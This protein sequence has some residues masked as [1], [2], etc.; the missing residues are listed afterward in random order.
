MDLRELVE[1]IL[2]EAVGA[3]PAP[4][5]RDYHA[6]WLERGIGREEPDVMAALGGAL[7]DRLA[8]VFVAGY[9]ATIR[10]CFPDLPVEPGWCAFV[11]TEEPSRGLP[12]TALTGE[13]GK[14][15]LSGAKTWVAAADHVDRLLVSAR[16]N[17]VPFVVL[18]RDAPGVEIACD[19]P[20][21]YLSEMVQGTVTFDDI[22]VREEQL[23]G[24]ARTFPVFR[25]AESAYVR[26]ALNV[27]MHGHVCRL[28]GPTA[29]IG[30]AVAG[31][32]GAAAVVQMQLPCQAAALGLLGVDR[33]T[34]ALAGE[35]ESFIQAQDETLHRLWT[36]DRRLV[37]GASTGIAARAAAALGR[38]ST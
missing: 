29:L 26:L 16:P 25:A 30:S 28:G 6:L 24:D 27:F 13:P 32:L 17:Q 3:V 19:P 9:Q 10:R 31:V 37:D 4:A 5:E 12:G 22:A 15:R 7:A 11:N 8:W 20:K 36:K 21:S 33:N 38:A 34:R 14:R 18:R 1:Q 35:F 23:T 2:S